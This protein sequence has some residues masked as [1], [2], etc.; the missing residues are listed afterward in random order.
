MRQA[1]FTFLVA[2]VLS[3]ALAVLSIL[4]Q[5]KGYPQGAVGLGRLDGI[6]AP[7]TFAPL[8]ALYALAAALVMILPLRAAGFMHG[9]GATPL[10][11]TV[12]VL[13]ASVVGIQLARLGFGN[14][15]AMRPLL[16]A[17]FAYAAIVVAAHLSLDTLRRNALLRSV[18]FAA[19]LA[20]VLFCLY[21]AL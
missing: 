14:T 21:V 3:A 2:V 6:A 19:F 13:F 8:G 5:Q 20:L 1:A 7:A 16:D 12:L 18:G 10:F 9:F 17:G 4:V 11:N 15:G